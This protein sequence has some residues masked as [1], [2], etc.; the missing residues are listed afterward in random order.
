VVVLAVVAAR[1]VLH[2]HHAREAAR[3]EAI[4][5][6]QARA[7]ADRLVDRSTSAAWLGAGAASDELVVRWLET[8]DS[9]LRDRVLARLTEFRESVG[10]DA[11]LVIDDQLRV[12]VADRDGSPDLSSEL[13]E[14]AQHALAAGAVRF[15]SIYRDEDANGRLRIDFVVPLSR[16][17]TPTRAVV[18]RFDPTAFLF[19][20]L[21]ARPGPGTSGESRLVRRVGDRMVGM[22]G[23]G[24]LRALT[25]PEPWPSDVL[26]GDTPLGEAV[27]LPDARGARVLAVVRPIPGTDWYLATQV[28]SSEVDAEARLQMAW[29]GGAGAMLLLSLVAIGWRLRVREALQFVRVDRAGRAEELRRLGMLAFIV[30]SSPDAIFVKDTA[31]R[32]LL[33]GKGAAERMG[34]AAAD[35][36]GHDDRAL[37]PADEAARL[38]ENDLRAMG[39]DRPLTFEEVVTTRAGRRTVLSTKG[40]LRDAAGRVIGVYG[41]S[42]DITERRLAESLQASQARI[43]DLIAHQA[44]VQRTLEELAVAI[45][46][47]VPGQ[48]CSV[49][50]YDEAARCL[51]VGAAPSLPVDFR[52]AVDCIRVEPNAGSCGAAAYR[53]EVVIVEDIRTDPLWKDF[54]ALAEPLGLRACWSTP[55]LDQDGKLLGTF[56][57]YRREPGAPTARDRRLIDVATHTAAICIGRAAAQATLHESEL[58]YRSMVSSLTEGVVVFD[59]AGRVLAC[60]P[61]AE[62]ILGVAHPQMAGEPGEPDGWALL[63]LD[64]APLPRDRWPLR[65]VLKTGMPVHGEVLGFRDPAGRTILLQINVEPMHDG[66]RQGGVVLSF[67]DVTRTHAAE[68]E[69]R[70]LSLAV[71]QSSNSI[72]ITGLDGRIQYVN[73]GFCRATGYTRGE[74]VG[75]LPK[76]LL[77]GRT[78]EQT[79]A[80]IMGTL[81]RGESWCGEFVNR[82]KDGAE[83]IEYSHISPIRQA[84]GRITHYLAIQQD[85]TE[86]KR[87]A[88][89][90]DRHRDHLEDLVHERTQQL[91]AANR[92]AAERALKIDALNA[93]LGHRA[94]EAESASRAKSSFLANMSHEIRTPMNAILGLTHLL[95]REAREPAQRERLAQVTGAARHLLQLV[96]DVLDLS[97]IETGKL[98][99]EQTEFAIDDVISRACTLVADRLREQELELIVDL[100]HVPHRLIGDPTRLL[101]ILLNLLTN[102]VK[103]TERGLIEVRCRVEHAGSDDVLLRTSVRDT[104]IG[105]APE[106]LGT[107]FTAFQQ[108]DSSTTRRFGG[109]G[110]GLAI[111]RH[112]VTLMGGEVG[113]ES[114]PGA[115][116]T[117]WFTARLQRGTQPPVVVESLHGRRALL[118]DDV[119]A[120]RAAIGGMLGR[121]GLR[122]DEAAAAEEA[123]ALAGAARDRQEPYAIALL[124]L[125]MAG[126]DG[127]QT[128]RRL[129]ALLGGAAPPCV[130]LGT[131]DERA[132]WQDARPSC[133]QGVLAKPVLP[134]A[135]QE[136][137]SRALGQ[138][139]PERPP[140]E[141]S[142]G[143]T[144]ARL[145]HDH[146]GAR[147]LLAEDNLVGQEVMGELLASV[148]LAVDIAATGAQAVQRAREARYDLVLMDMQM[149]EMDGIEA[150]KLIRALP[151]Y[152]GVPIVAVTANAFGDDRAACLA[153]G[154]NDH[155]GKP[156]DP[157]TLYATLLR[158]LARGAG[159]GPAAEAVASESRPASAVA[160]L[161]SGIPGLDAEGV[162]ARFGGRADLV[163]RILRRFAAHYAAGVPDLVEQM[164]A[165]DVDAAKR[166]VHSLRGAAGQV[167]A[168]HVQSLAA[169][170]EEALA[171][172]TSDAG[173]DALLA[174]MNEALAAFVA[175]VSAR[176]PAD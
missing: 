54:L 111:V 20:T 109:T 61:S 139:A 152:R 132:V 96:N 168:T 13:R 148:G 135:L 15:T 57:I 102:A 119:P 31:S 52:R 146:A 30:E 75:K 94:A 106:K 36:I 163:V 162:L 46:A 83:C 5:D 39:T 149:P 171:A 28:D 89:E 48:S 99:L 19:S 133:V 6:L 145:R 174:V 131:H 113:A 125:H 49:M 44:P 88:A 22:F 17:G 173:I 123:L 37:F 104:G 51:R 101:Q 105:I 73:D 77:P 110:L 11:V 66:G 98:E 172:A 161:L 24:A 170:V 154:M 74:V 150:T 115:G 156:V 63:D 12:L 126:I 153:A 56:A 2:H 35:V 8:G 147:V 25:A 140:A 108:A 164:R 21:Q 64:G 40:A 82:R 176:L 114:E 112:L 42:R 141:A 3:I 18:L 129:Q 67:T 142:G 121:L 16:P 43:L 86:Q 97:K 69:L 124:D 53:R 55:I 47:Q 167:G 58:R 27:E 90:L 103:F 81:E 84:D 65:R 26:R 175:T 50:L 87:I 137:V 79:Y 9:G 72:V 120:A 1:F 71:E 45:E 155:L 136:C 91:E 117:F 76:P 107:L 118:V 165:G 59:R 7:I 34:K 122:V 41:I 78:R 144:E 32:Y 151:G 157:G 60:N 68:Q 23:V 92:A 29:I 33:F 116:S 100:D 127:M 80:E 138:S 166:A 169:Q 128:I 70:K 159:E 134:S 160:D 38:R 130:L 14:L 4:A 62:R 95:Q 93:E 10:G 85:V 143:Q 158:W